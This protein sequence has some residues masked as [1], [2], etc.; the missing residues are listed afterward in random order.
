M[1]YQIRINYPGQIDSKNGENIYGKSVF[2]KKSS[3][4]KNINICRK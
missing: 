1:I 2:G 3:F 4:R